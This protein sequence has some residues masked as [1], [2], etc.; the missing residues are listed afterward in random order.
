MGSCLMPI[1]SIYLLFLMKLPFILGPWINDST[2]DLKWVFFR[3]IRCLVSMCINFFFLRISPNLQ[4]ELQSTDSQS[5]HLLKFLYPIK[6]D[7]AKLKYFFLRWWN[8]FFFF[9]FSMF[10]FVYSWPRCLHR[11][12]VAVCFVW[13]WRRWFL[14]CH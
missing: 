14:F 5:V 11:L 4:V 6:A 8:F 10:H 12:I 7:V 3:F 1:Y 2:Y 9:L 13:F